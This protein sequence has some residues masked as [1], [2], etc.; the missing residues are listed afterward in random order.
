MSIAATLN[1]LPIHA[2]PVI[3]FAVGLVPPLLMPGSRSL[4]ACVLALGVLFSIALYVVG[5][6]VADAN[7]GLVVALLLVPI[8]AGFIGCV[9]GGA[10]QTVV[11]STRSYRASAKPPE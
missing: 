2:W 11:L 4:V 5:N 7:N 8:A 3:G 6:G 9:V 10:I 1:S